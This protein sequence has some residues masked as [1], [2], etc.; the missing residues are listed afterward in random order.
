MTLESNITDTKDY[1]APTSLFF[2]P[3]QLW[4]WREKK[5]ILI[6]IIGGDREVDVQAGREKPSV[7]SPLVSDGQRCLNL[8]TR[9]RLCVTFCRTC[10]YN[11]QIEKGFC[12]LRGDFKVLAPAWFSSRR[13]GGTPY[14]AHFKGLQ[15]H[16][17]WAMFVLMYYF[18][19]PLC[20]LW[21]LWWQLLCLFFF[22]F[23]TLSC[24]CHFCT[25]SI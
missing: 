15:V 10:H 14:K 13:Q 5:K 11:Y 25:L 7:L 17:P 9:L 1:F 22:F 8:T 2:L 21:H 3:H 16:P 18:H 20:P 24:T 23:P 4:L 12:A 19:M 6:L